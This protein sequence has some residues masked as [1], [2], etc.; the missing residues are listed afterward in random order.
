MPHE[1]YKACNHRYAFQFSDLQFPPFKLGVS[2][3]HAPGQSVS[4]MKLNRV[5]LCSRRSQGLPMEEG[6]MKTGTLCPSLQ[7]LVSAQVI[8]VL[9]LLFQQSPQGKYSN[10]SHFIEKEPQTQRAGVNWGRWN[11]VRTHGICLQGSGA[12]LFCNATLAGH[13]QQWATGMGKVR[14]DVLSIRGKHRK[15][16]CTWIN[17][18]YCKKKV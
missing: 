6:R 3:V 17:Q 8:H 10:E 16:L 7:G 11:G 15:K 14:N 9:W 1:Y 12:E 2:V 13:L 4:V 18:W 5:T